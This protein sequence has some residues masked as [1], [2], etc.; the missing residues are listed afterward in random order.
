[1]RFDLPTFEEPFLVA[2]TD[3]APMQLPIADIDEDPDQPRKEFDETALNE[4]AATIA[5]RG[6]RQPVSVRPHPRQPGRWLLNFGARRLRASKL[7]GKD[8]LPAFIDAHFDSY[9]QVI[10][11]EQRE[12]LKPIELALFVERQLK[13]GQSQSEV[14]RRL[15]KS[16][17]FIS[18]VAAL[19]DPPDWL[20]ALYRDGRC[21]GLKELCDLRRLHE[22][23]P[24]TVATWLEGRRFVARDDVED[25]RTKL[26]DER[27]IPASTTLRSEA[28]SKHPIDPDSNLAVPLRN[29]VVPSAR[30]S[31]RM[32]AQMRLTADLRGSRVRVL[33]EPPSPAANSVFVQSDDGGPMH[34]VLIEHL[35]S[36]RITSG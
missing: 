17:S 15:G 5:E 12:A 8:V 20:L 25:L 14:G 3:G 9:D 30:P 32:H 31:P 7:V 18:Y 29:S 23:E 21:R 24:A 35:D 33:L 26:R 36:L 13:L 1:M 6:V 11:N 10:E 4:L 22:R 16:K 34:S 27:N 28:N 2:P 19:I